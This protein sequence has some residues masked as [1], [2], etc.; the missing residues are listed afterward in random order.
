[1]LTGGE[2]KSC[3]AGDVSMAGAYVSF[4]HDKPILKHVKINRY[5]YADASQ[6]HEPER[7]RFLLL[8]APE[9]KRLREAATQKGITI[10]PL[11]MRAGKYIKVLLGVARGRKT[12]D[13]RQR[14]KER[15]VGRRIREGR[16]I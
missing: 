4:L 15:E 3:R 1:M 6:Q 16:E 7:D 11:E 2:V 10:V 14:I 8:K 5:R 13:K 9:A 12:L